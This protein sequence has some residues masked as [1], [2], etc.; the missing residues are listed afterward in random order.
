MNSKN[1]VQWV[2]SSKDNKEL[3]DRYDHWAKDYDQDL[4]KDFAYRGPQVAAEYFAR[5]VRTDAKV[6]DAGAGTGLVGEI[7]SKMGYCNLIAMDMSQGML[8]EARKKKV[9]KKLHRMVMGETLGFKTNYF[10]AVIC[11]GTLSL[12]HAPANSLYELVRITKPGGCIVYTLRP[13]VYKE[14]GFKKIQ[15]K[16][17]S[18]GSWKLVEESEKIQV[19][20]KGEPDIY[21]KIWIYQII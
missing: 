9:Y 16:L 13:D 3:E 1:R 15:N 18:D 2:Y 17:E 8:K 14:K 6:L 21:H 4:E 11:V 19:L 5:Y 7:L 20:P 10:D 12:G